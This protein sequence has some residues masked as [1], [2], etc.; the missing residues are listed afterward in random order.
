MVD[1]GT[2]WRKLDQN[3][4][5]WNEITETGSNWCTLEQNADAETGLVK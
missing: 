5:R 2:K 3:G 1:A 4:G